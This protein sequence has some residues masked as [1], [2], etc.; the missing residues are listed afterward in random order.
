MFSDS[1]VGPIGSEAALR[2]KESRKSLSALFCARVST[3]SR[4]S[5]Y[6]IPETETAA[7]RATAAKTAT[8][9]SRRLVQRTMPGDQFQPRARRGRSG[10]AS[11][12]PSRPARPPGPGHARLPGPGPRSAPVV[13]LRGHCG[14]SRRYPR[15]GPYG[16]ASVTTARPRSWPAAAARTRRPAASRPGSRAPTPAEQ[17]LP[18]T[19]PD[20]GRRLSSS[21]SRSSVGVEPDRCA[22]L[23]ARSCAPRSMTSSSRNAAEPV[24]SRARRG[25]APR[26]SGRPAPGAAPA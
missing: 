2:C 13:G 12:P 9:R 7:V 19:A 26:G 21:S 23:A 22:V 6:A 8:S 24:L 5:Q 15:L 14:V 16:S 25:A 4:L 10:P 11:G 17:L 1:Q 20:P 3:A 18:R